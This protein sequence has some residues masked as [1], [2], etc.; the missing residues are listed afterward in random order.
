M[1]CGIPLI[2]APWNDTEGLFSPGVDYLVAHDSVE[3]TAALKAVL[4]DSALSTSLSVHGLE[5]IRK[6]HSCAHRVNE[7]LGIMEQLNEVAV[8]QG[9]I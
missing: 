7:L 2:S 8:T 9:A 1:A 4:T 5:T 6:R 3:M